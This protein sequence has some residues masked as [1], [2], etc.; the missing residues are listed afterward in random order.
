MFAIEVETQSECALSGYAAPMMS[1]AAYGPLAHLGCGSEL[2]LP[3]VD[4]C[5]GGRPCQAAKSR[6]LRNVSTG[7]ARAAMAVAVIGPTPSIV[8]N[9]E[10]ISSSLACL[11]ISGST[12][13]PSITLAGQIGGNDAAA[14]SGSE[15]CRANDAVLD[16]GA[17]NSSFSPFCEQAR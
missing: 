3:P 16:Q 2:C 17:F 15:L 8:I 12:P 6:S 11:A 9:R 7:E 13:K 10:G 4:R 14:S 1:R 5:T